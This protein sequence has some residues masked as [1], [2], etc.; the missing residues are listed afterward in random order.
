MLVEDFIKKSILQDKRNIFGKASSDG[1][2]P[3][4]LK[5]FYKKANPVD[6]EITMGGNVIRFVPVDEL[7]DV[8]HNY[9]LGDERFVFATCNGDPIYVY[10]NK[11]YTCCH[12]INEIDDELVADNF[13]LFLDLID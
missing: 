10:M 4:I 2:I 7:S 6:V 11:I 5:E 3:N 13:S 1:S 8:Q 9:K 12:G